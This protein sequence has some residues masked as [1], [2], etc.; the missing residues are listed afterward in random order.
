MSCSKVREQIDDWLDYPAGAKMPETAAEH[1]KRCAECRLF[2][3]NWH[4]VEA[5]LR[6]VRDEAPGLSDGFRT[7]LRQRLADER[8]RRSPFRGYAFPRFAAAG[9]FALMLLVLLI[10]VQW[11]KNRNAMLAAGEPVQHLPQPAVIDN[12]TLPSR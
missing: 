3:T 12:G 7:S 11:V 10:S 5:Q 9:A 1:L 6:A 2:V 8:N 4:A